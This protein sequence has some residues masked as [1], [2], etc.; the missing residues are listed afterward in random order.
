MDVVLTIAGI[1]VIALGLWDMFHSLLHPEGQGTLSHLMLAGVWKA[2]SMMRHRLGSAAG[3]GGMVTVI[4]MWVLLQSV[5]WVLVYLPRIPEGFSYPG[6]D[7][8]NYSGV[9]EALYMSFTSLSTV[10][11][12]DMVAIDP[13]T[14]I[15][16]PLQAL[17]GFA[18]LTAALTWFTQVYPP[19]ARRR[20]LALEL[21][22]LR[23]AGYVDKLGTLDPTVASG[24]LD[25]V[26]RQAELASIDFIQHSE[27]YFFVEVHPDLSLARQLPHALEFRDAARRVQSPEVQLATQRLSLSLDRLGSVLNRFVFASGRDLEAIFSAYAAD[28]EKSHSSS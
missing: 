23:R 8:A 3:P 20:A 19:L 18:L 14:R 21:S 4:L 2:S 6:V 7:P 5:G 25:G 27:S 24:L 12:G 16:S 15:A 1:A 26:A 28:H 17:T 22:N 9:A 11:F 10:G 13:W